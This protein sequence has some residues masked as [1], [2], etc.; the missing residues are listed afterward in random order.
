MGASSRTSV[1][2]LA[3]AELIVRAAAASLF[4]V[5]PDEDW[6]CAWVRSPDGGVLPG[7]LQVRCGG[8]RRVF[9]HDGQVVGERGVAVAS[10]IFEELVAAG[11]LV[12]DRW[13]WLEALGHLGVIPAPVWQGPHWSWTQVESRYAVSYVNPSVVLASRSDGGASLTVYR[14]SL[15]G[16]GLRGARVGVFGAGQQHDGAGLPGSTHLR[17]VVDLTAAGQL[18]AWEEVEAWFGAERRWI[19]VDALGGVEDSINAPVAPASQVGGAEPDDEG[20]AE[21]ALPYFS[22]VEHL[23]DAFGRVALLLERHCSRHWYRLVDGSRRL[24]DVRVSLYE[25]QRV[26]VGASD[27]VRHA[28]ADSGLRSPVEL[29][30]LLATH[31]AA[32]EARAA[33]TIGGH[34]VRLPLE[35]LRAMFNL[36]AREMD[37][38]LVLAGLQLDPGLARVATWAWADANVR[39]ATVG[40]VA[41]VVS[42]TDEE[43]LRA[44]RVGLAGHPLAALGLFELSAPERWGGPAPAMQL[45]IGLASRITTFLTVDEAELTTEAK[46]AMSGLEGCARLHEPS[47]GARLGHPTAEVQAELVRA[48]R[49]A[50]LHAQR[51]APGADLRRIGEHTPVVLVAAVDPRMVDLAVQPCVGD[52]RLLSVDLSRARLASASSEVV[53]RLLGAVLREARLVDAFVHIALGDVAD[54]AWSEVLLPALVAVLP[55]LRAPVVLSAVRLTRDLYHRIGPCPRLTLSMPDAGQRAALWQHHLAGPVSRQPEL[56]YQV[57]SLAN[58][59]VLTPFDVEDA[60][61]QAMMQSGVEGADRRRGTL[62]PEDIHRAVREQIEHKLRALAEPFTTSLTWDDL[63]LPPELKQRLAEIVEYGG[64][65]RMVN[66]EWGFDRLNSYGGGLS[67]LFG[68]PPGTG[69]TLSAAIVAR[70]MGY[71]LYRVDLSRIVDKYI[72]ETEKNLSRIFD[73]AERSRAALLFDEADSLFAKRTEVKSSTDR[74]A[75][76]EVTY[77]LQRME[78]FD[79]VSFLTTNLADGLDE[80]F[81]RRIKFRLDFRM[82]DAEQREVLWRGMMPVRAPVGDDIQWLKLAR[83]F[84]MAPGHIKNAVVRA[85]FM[86]ARDRHVIDHAVLWK[87]AV[88]EYR[89]LGNLIREL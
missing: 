18:S 79:G 4:G 46:L 6:A 1:I 74:Y 71:E 59:Y 2:E 24:S 22:A 12:Q 66:E 48:L 19:P 16:G 87:A 83:T 61:Q 35:D 23:R 41:E 36:D 77:L 10:R 27:G 8:L 40:F 56:A 20:D 67:A 13:L 70:E 43:R 80:A 37:L 52:Q 89:E 17:W 72:G 14:E 44:A 58:Q 25:V 45:R 55:H 63:I 65:A 3:E 32:M 57:P 78:N 62:E 60:V 64:N 73:E 38:L 31:M 42:S 33:A 5:E 81:Q 30:G 28:P 86:A 21:G 88:I 75:N 9:V 29:D 15:D 47:R 50:R 76:Q 26:L 49:V 7:L 82:P 11:V 68:G 53:A 84:E 39:Q 69:K 51:S 85:A 54:D 34:A